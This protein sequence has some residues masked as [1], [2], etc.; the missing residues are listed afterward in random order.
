MHIT[1]PDDYYV[2][3]IMNELSLLAI[4]HSSGQ[5]EAHIDVI[6]VYGG[7]GRPTFIAIHRKLRSGRNWDIVTGT[8][9]ADPA[10]QAALW[11]CTRERKPRP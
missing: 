8:D 5:L 10:E 7:E 3:S 2:A 9:P 4:G 1:M 11:R 6:A